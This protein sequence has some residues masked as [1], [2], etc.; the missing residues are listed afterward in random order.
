MIPSPSCRLKLLVCVFCAVL[1]LAIGGPSGLAGVQVR[2]NKS[3]TL[4]ALSVRPD[5][6]GP[7][8]HVTGD[9]VVVDDEILAGKAYGV[10]AGKRLVLRSSAAFGGA[11]A[12]EALVRFPSYSGGRAAESW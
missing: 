5:A 8:W 10:P 2:V 1:V 11:H 9:P 3:Q 12:V 7:E 4:V 6:L